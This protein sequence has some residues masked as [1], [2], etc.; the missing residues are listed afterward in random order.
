MLSIRGERVPHCR[1]CSMYLVDFDA[2]CPARIRF[3]TDSVRVVADGAEEAEKLVR[4]Y[5]YNDLEYDHIITGD[6]TLIG[7]VL[8]SVREDTCK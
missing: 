1:L 5:L 8:L 4:A 7:G 3:I 2:F 6:V